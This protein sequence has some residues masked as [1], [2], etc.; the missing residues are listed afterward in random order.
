MCLK[1]WLCDSENEVLSEQ[2]TST[3]HTVSSAVTTVHSSIQWFPHGLKNRKLLESNE[4]EKP[5]F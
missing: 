4:N 3:L 2:V 5:L 1:Q